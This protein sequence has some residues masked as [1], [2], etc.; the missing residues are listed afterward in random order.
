MTLRI[1]VIGTGAMG[2]NHV[3]VLS[4]LKDRCRLDGVFDTDAERAA[5]IAREF[6]TKPFPTLKMLIDSLDAAVVAV[7]IFAHY[8][9]VK[10][11]LEQ[12]VHVLVEKPMTATIEEAEKLR[13]L[14]TEKGLKLQVGHIELFNPTIRVLN[15]ILQQEELIAIDI[16]RLSPFEERVKNIDVIMD[17]M[18]HDLYI[19]S[20]LAGRDPVSCTAYGRTLHQHLNHV[21]A[22][23][24]YA[25]GLIATL[26]A[27]IVT[28]EKVR[29]IRVVTKKAYVQADL[30]DKKILI[31]RSTNFFLSNH[32]CDY[33]QQNI[34]EKVIVPPYEPLREQLIHFIDCI[35]LD[36]TPLVAAD[37]GLETLRM[38]EE[39]KQNMINYHEAGKE[40]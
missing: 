28:E 9:V 12:G 11:C 16:Q 30:M 14:A 15:N 27:S 2:K 31:S 4:G 19:L 38:A 24:Q 1:G 23:F 13:D 7:P 40:R 5:M 18:I 25:D 6:G 33:K 36:K 29:T 10:Q 32:D 26:T 37:Q 34:I 35:R 8:D 39:V 17:T 20:Y 21:V 22:T 3:R